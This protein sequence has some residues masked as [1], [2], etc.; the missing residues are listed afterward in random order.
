MW[1]NSCVEEAVLK[2]GERYG[3]SGE[4][5]MRELFG[6]GVGA[7][8]VEKSK[9][10]KSKEKK[11]K[12]SIPLP[13]N[14]EFDESRCFGLHTNH[15]LFTQC[16][17]KRVG[18]KC[19]CIAHESQADKN[20]TGTPDNGTIQQRLASD[21]LNFTTPSGKPVTPYSKIMKKFNITVEQAQEEAGKVNV[22]IDS[23]HFM[24]ADE[25]AKKGRPKKEKAPK[26]AKAT[27]GR[28]K[29]EK[30]SV[31]ISEPKED[32]FATLVAQAAAESSGSESGSESEPEPESETEM[33]AM[34][35]ADKE[36]HA[37]E[38]EVKKNEKKAEKEAKKAQEK[39]DKKALEDAAKAE[40]KAQEE[41]A[42]AE[43]KAKEE[44]AKAEKKAQEEAAKAEKKAKEEAAKAEKKAKEEAAKAEK[45]AKE[46]A[47]KA[48]KKTKEPSKK[49]PK[50]AVAKKEEPK[51]EPKPEPEPAE[52]EESEDEEEE[53]EEDT[54][55][56]AKVESKMPDVVNWFEFEGKKYLKSKNTGI[57]YSTTQEVVGKW[58]T[59]TNRIDFNEEEEEED[60]SESSDSDSDGEECEEDNYEA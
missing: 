47:A 10:S 33:S 15:G 38:K 48:E 30:M 17:L 13:F 26:E 22:T 56:A 8:I 20:S 51:P 35:A 39:A 49:A 45:K 27:K 4:E 52:S 32:L 18:E 5:A 28:P 3:F 11:V 23:R 2:C 42:K 14:G 31:E 7:G 50:K 36:S 41:A 37:A 21:L 43:K 19:Y 6:E 40:K 55:D 1:L 44:A 53:E 25:E 57:V 60:E 46:E 54:Y 24:V 58:N 16:S 34:S 29:K 9:K 12:A 59:T